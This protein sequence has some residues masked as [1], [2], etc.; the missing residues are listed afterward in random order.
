MPI[1]WDIHEMSTSCPLI[2]TDYQRMDNLWTV[3]MHFNHSPTTS[4][5]PTIQDLNM[6]LLRT[7]FQSSHCFGALFVFFPHTGRDQDFWS[8]HWGGKPHALVHEDEKG[9]GEHRCALLTGVSWDMHLRL[10]SATTYFLYHHIRRVR[11]SCRRAVFSPTPQSMVEFSM[12]S[13][14]CQDEWYVTCNNRHWANTQGHRASSKPGCY[15]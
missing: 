11:N 7:Y 15:L 6:R 5:F 13:H 1:S 3:I 4:T 8:P 12:F 9:E 10:Q 14:S 2:S